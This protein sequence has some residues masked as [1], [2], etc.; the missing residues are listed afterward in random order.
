MKKI[1]GLDLGTNSVGWAVI[2]S[3][4]NDEGKEQLVNISSCGSR[5]IPMDAATLGD[6]DKGNS[7]S[8][9]AER[10]RLRGVRRLLER[11]LLRRERLHRVL[12][13]MEFLPEHYA[14][15]LDRYGKFLPEREPKLAWY[16]DETG[17]YRFLF[18]DSFNEMLEDFRQHHPELVAEGKKIPYDWTIYYLRKKALS[19]KIT[20]EELAWILLNFNQKRGYYQLRGEEE[21]E[22]NK[23]SVEYYA[24]KVVAVED[25]GDRKGKD[26]WYN[27]KLENGWVY[28]RASS[29]PLDWVGKVKEFI[30]T[31]DLD[32]KGNPK[33][34]KDGNVKRSFR[35][36]KEDDWGLLKTRTQAQ[37]DESGQTVGTYIYE[38]LLRMPDQKIRGKLVRTIERKYYKD[39]LRK[40]LIKQ[41][42]FHAALLDHNL[43]LACIE[44][45]YPN[46][47][48]H[49]RLLSTSDFTNFLV[50]DILFYQ[51][52]LKSQK[53]LID[54]CPYES[55]VYRDKKN[56]SLQHVPLKCVSK[57]HPLFQEFRLW[58][59]LASLRIYQREK[60]VDGSLKLDV[61][62]TN[63]FL[64]GEDDYVKLFD[65]LND[66]KDIDQ[67]TILTYKPFGLKKNELPKYRWN[68]VEDKSYPCNETRA[69]I[70]SRLNKA[71]VPEEFLTREKEEALWHILYS[72][73][74]KKKLTK[75]LGTFA[76]KNGLYL[77]S[78]N[79]QK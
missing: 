59:F 67:K 50:E 8:P 6:F 37:I 26:I 19:Q 38:S 54:N 71:G 20:K 76:E 43:L 75:A 44:E 14:S 57:S 52:P 16:Q 25:S 22:D 62:V 64:Q 74:D 18:Q 46:N 40:I 33:K 42:E 70:I 21:K 51:R 24:L 17:K 77:E 12:S 9:V 69:D 73:S 47:E 49:R 65:W 79:N 35:A 63:E 32:E 29:I 72:I 23:K 5:I 13:V 78:Q 66:R 28:R 7:K 3:V 39:E 55:H 2:N 31:T 48:A 15:Q 45:L 68:Y 27:V 36:P 10:T 53:G 58:Q 34:D 56:G 4:V 61:D 11:S 30:V 41:S 1:L 60:Q